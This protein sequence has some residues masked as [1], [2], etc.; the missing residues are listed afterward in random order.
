MKE[1]EMKTPELLST[2]FGNGNPPLPTAPEPIAPEPVK[3]E[4]NKALSPFTALKA[5]Q[6]YAAPMDTQ[7][8]GA[9]PPIKGG[10]SEN[11]STAGSWGT[12]K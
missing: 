8:G 1:K 12:P 3:V 5:Q 2:V 10:M 11:M 9:V 7:T 4:K 6:V